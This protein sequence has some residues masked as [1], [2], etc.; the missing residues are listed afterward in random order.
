[1]SVWL[2]LVNQSAPLPAPG[3]AG[4]FVNQS[5]PG[6]G[7]SEWTTANRP[8]ENTDVVLWYTFGVHHIPRPEDWP[9]MP[10]DMVSF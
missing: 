1:M 3:Q 5:G 9:V 8:I 7:L 4:E 6:L 2:L 10:A